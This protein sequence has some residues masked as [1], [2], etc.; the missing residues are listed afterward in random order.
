MDVLKCKRQQ[1][2]VGSCLE[3]LGNLTLLGTK[4]P[5]EGIASAGDAADAVSSILKAIQVKQTRELWA[6]KT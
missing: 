3:N 6:P 5:A 1:M 4:G 2:V